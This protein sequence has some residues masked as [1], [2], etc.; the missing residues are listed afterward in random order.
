MVK[1][2]LK[3]VKCGK[4]TDHEVRSPSGTNVAICRKCYVKQRRLGVVEP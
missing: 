2:P 4:R 1:M 3:C